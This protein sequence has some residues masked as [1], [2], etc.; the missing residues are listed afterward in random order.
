MSDE[1]EWAEQVP[2]HH[3]LAEQAVLGSM[4]IEAEA[5]IRARQILEPRDFYDEKHRTIFKA[6]VEMMDGAGA[7]GIDT[8]TVTEELRA[9]GKLEEVGGQSALAEIVTKVVSAA[10]VEHYA[11][12]V[13]RASL[14]RQVDEDLYELRENKTP[15]RVAELGRKIMAMESLGAYDILD[16]QTDLEAVIQVIEKEDPGLPLG[17]P[18][19][20]GLFVGQKKGD[21]TAV[22]SGTGGGKTA[23]LTKTAVNLAKMPES[24]ARGGVLYITTEMSKVE[25]LFRILPME[26][27]I[28]SDR[29]IRKTL[30]KEDLGHIV[31]ISSDR[32]S[33]LRLKIWAK[34]RLSL[35]DLRGVV[36]HTRAD[37]VIIDHLQRC[38]YPKADNRTY[39]IQEFMSELKTFSQEAKI[40]TM[41]GVQLDRNL[42][43]DLKKRPTLADFKDSAAI[44]QESSNAILLWRPPASLLEGPDP[45]KGSIAMEAIFAKQR[46]GPAPEIGW[47]Q[48]NGKLVEISERYEQTEVQEEMKYL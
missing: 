45:D 36:L 6:V 40:R 5:A 19:L 29:F 21:I 14:N 42:Y 38:R 24:Q 11:N 12:L 16:F 2:L 32:L 48:L 23:F 22:G 7:L 47:L 37:I 20:D 10:H 39:A 15:K 9:Q 3:P 35:E 34:P 26:T 46:N 17:F 1:R 13:R 44:E 18:H 43:R 30:T 41:L 31:E 8:V 27:G 25:M 33:K 28:P 4:L